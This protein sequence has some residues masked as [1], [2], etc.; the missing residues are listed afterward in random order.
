MPHDTFEDLPATDD[1]GRLCD[2][3]DD[4]ASLDRESAAGLGL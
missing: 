2:C 4:Y 1:A 3:L